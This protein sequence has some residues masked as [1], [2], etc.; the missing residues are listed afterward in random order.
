MLGMVHKG[1]GEY[2]TL[3]LICITPDV[4]N[5][6]KTLNEGFTMQGIDRDAIP[7]DFVHKNVMHTDRNKDYFTFIEE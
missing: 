5:Y 3:I 1:Y 2:H 6:G 4:S 7:R